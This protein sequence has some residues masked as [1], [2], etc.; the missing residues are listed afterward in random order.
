MW[1]PLAIEIERD[2]AHVLREAGKHLA[3]AEEF[4]S[5]RIV[6]IHF[7]NGRGADARTPIRAGVKTGAEHHNLA[8][9]V[10]QNLVR[11]VVNQ[12]GEIG[13]ASCRERV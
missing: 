9:L 7:E 11:G 4:P 8:E 6:V 12:T 5:E 3:Q 10:V 1:K 2:I 13:R